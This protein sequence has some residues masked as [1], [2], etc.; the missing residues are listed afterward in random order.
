LTEPNGI[1][2]RQHELFVRKSTRVAASYLRRVKELS[3]MPDAAKPFLR[4]WKTPM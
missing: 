2:E 1:N 3:D 4:C